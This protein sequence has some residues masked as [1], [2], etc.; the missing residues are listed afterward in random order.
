MVQML[1]KKNECKSD[2]TSSVNLLCISILYISQICRR[3]ILCCLSVFEDVF[4]VEGVVANS[5]IVCR[6]LYVDSMGERG[7]RMSLMAYIV[8]A[9]IPFMAGMLV[10][11]YF[12][13][14]KTFCV[15]YESNYEI[16]KAR[17][18]IAVTIYAPIFQMSDLNA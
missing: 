11:L 12:R 14:R 16:H 4:A 15:D 2:W 17:Q 10:K 3:W 7:T 13:F 8:G 18:V 9:S 1:M 6:N 5:T